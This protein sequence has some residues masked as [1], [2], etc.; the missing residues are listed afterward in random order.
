MAVR[1]HTSAASREPLILWMA[2]AYLLGLYPVPIFF[3]MHTPT[4]GSRSRRSA[5]CSL[6]REGVTGQSGQGMIFLVRWSLEPQPSAAMALMP[7][8]RWR[9]WLVFA[10]FKFQGLCQD[11]C[12]QAPVHHYALCTCCRTPAL[13]LW[14]TGCLCT[15]SASPHRSVMATQWSVLGTSLLCLAAANSPP[16]RITTICTASGL[17]RPIAVHHRSGTAG[18]HHCT[19]Y[20][21]REGPPHCTLRQWPHTI[22]CASDAQCCWA[23]RGT[24][25]MLQKRLVFFFVFP[26]IENFR[27]FR[28]PLRHAVI[29]RCSS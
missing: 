27:A 29:H 8:L 19:E 24:V 3:S 4:T 22:F 2:D 9:L 20:C 12:A 6:P 13:P 10:G 11:A 15:R 23:P 16:R 7:A 17:C 25:Q 1:R 18:V 5:P 28:R 21:G 26:V 14:S